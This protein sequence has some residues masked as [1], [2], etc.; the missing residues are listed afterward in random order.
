M[1]S[2]SALLML[3]LTFIP[4][5]ACAHD[6]LC[7]DSFCVF[8]AGDLE[9]T[10]EHV[11]FN[12]YVLEFEGNVYFIYEG[13]D[14]PLGG[15]IVEYA[16]APDTNYLAIYSIS[17]GQANLMIDRSVFRNE[18]DLEASGDLTYFNSPNYSKL[19]ISVQCSDV[20][21]L[22]GLRRLHGRLSFK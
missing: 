22:C 14:P 15:R 20:Q 1:K 9:K 3:S 7:G 13:Y 8:G 16:D 11:D 17:N 18:E 5:T 4:L 6:K 2:S 10:G 12:E 21:G 19:K